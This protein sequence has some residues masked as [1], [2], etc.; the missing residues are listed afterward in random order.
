MQ[1]TIQVRAVSKFYRRGSL[2]Q[3]VLNNVELAVAAGEFLSLMGP[4]GSGKTTLLNI[5]SGLDRPNAGAVVFSGAVLDEM[6]ERALSRW[7]AQNIGFIFQ[8]YNLLATLSA[9]QNVELPLLLSPLGRAERRRRAEIALD[10]VGLKGRGDHRSSELSGGEQQRV[11]IARAIAADPPVL[12][13]D[14]PTGDLD[15]KSA[16]E[17]LMLLTSLSRDFGKTIVMVTH[18]SRAAAH[19]D[20]NLVMDKGR[21]LG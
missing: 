4:S 1:G 2:Q 5:M 14:E 15:R 6:S 3:D 16:D 7:R 10:I 9:R 19:A 8:F 21:L 11:A 12:M 17:I 20:R 18:D 13:C